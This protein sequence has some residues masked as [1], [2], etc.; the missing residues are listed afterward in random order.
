MLHRAEQG[1]ATR[2]GAARRSAGGGV[3]DHIVFNILNSY[4]ANIWTQ[5]ISL[6]VPGGNVC[7]VTHNVKLLL[8]ILYRM[9]ARSRR[10]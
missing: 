10:A 2:R 5:Y 3:E 6:A 4:M 9:A 8:C 7:Y 1:G